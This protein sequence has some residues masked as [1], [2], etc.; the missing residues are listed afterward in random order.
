MI[1]KI[2][3]IALLVIPSFAW[4][5]PAVTGVS[6]TVSNGESIT[7]TGTDFGATGPTVKLF[8]DF[9]AGTSSEYIG[10]GVTNAVVGT[11]EDCGEACTPTYYS[12]YSTTQAHSGTKSAR[13]NWAN[14]PSPDGGAMWIGATLDGPVTSIYFSFWVYLPTGQNV[15][16]SGGGYGANWKVWWLQRNSSHADD[17]ASEIVT[18]PPSETSLCYVDGTTNRLC[19]G[20]AGFDFSKGQWQRFEVYLTASTSSGVGQLW[21]MSAS[22]ARNLWANE[23]GRTIDDGSAGWYLL[24]MP[25]YARYDSNS[26][27]Y[28]DD[29]YVAT[30]SSA[31]ARVEICN[32]ATYT[33]STN[34]AIATPTSWANTSITATVRQGSFGASDTAYLFVIDSS[35]VASAGHEVTFGS[36]GETPVLRKLNNVTGVRVTLH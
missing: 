15:P 21:F 25:G 35:G 24:R 23:T 12:I 20:Y 27:T 11:W 4:A 7:I 36:G 9:E 6:G 22:Q 1:Y 30:G 3:L 31:R 34:C 13:Q 18:D 16:G 17:F 26:N 2:I 28:Y 5:A 32:N 10:N 19:Y 14:S 29:V 33:N 8:D